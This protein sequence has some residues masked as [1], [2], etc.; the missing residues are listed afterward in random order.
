MKFSLALLFAAASAASTD[1]S[2]SSTSSTTTTSNTSGDFDHSHTADGQSVV[3]EYNVV[4]TT[5]T[6]EHIDVGAA[7][8]DCVN[9]VYS[10]LFLVVDQNLIHDWAVV[11]KAKYDL[12]MRDWE[13]SLEHF[14]FEIKALN[15]DYWVMFRPLI[16]AR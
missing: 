13:R 5:V 9:C 4:T 10:D 2:S 6:T 15:E 1:T 3:A 11:L 7:P 16:Q 12:L 14:E 8:V